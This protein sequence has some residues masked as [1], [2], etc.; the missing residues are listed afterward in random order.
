M[1]KELGIGLV[2]YKFMGKAHSNAWLNAPKFFDL[3]AQPVM[4]AVCGRTAAAVKPFADNW[5]WQSVET[6]YRK[7]I[8]RDDIHLIDVATPNHTHYAIAM[9]AIKARKHVACEKPLAM[10]TPQ[11][12]EMACAAKEAKLVHT[13]WFNYRRCPAAGLARQIIREGRLGVIR[14]VRAVYL[15]DWIVNPEFPLVWRLDKK[16][17]GSGAHGDLNAHLIDLTRF[18]TGLEF[19][20]VTGLA[21]TFIKQR[22]RVASDKGDLRAKSGKGT[23]KVTVDDTVLF[24]ARLQ[25]NVVA[26][27]EAT[28]FALGRRNHNRIEINGSKGS[29]AWCFERMNELEFFS[30]A[31]P[32][33]LQGFRTIQATEACH[34]YVGAYWPAGHG[35]GYEHAFVNQAADIVQ[36]T[37]ARRKIRPDFPDGLRCQEVMDAVLRSCKTKRWVAVKRHQ[38]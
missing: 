32:Q 7:L 2:G 20:E 16:I 1:Q 14:H 19:E 17:A 15:Q 25:K 6:D 13:V 26:T 34:P 8:R 22:P 37:H 11:A 24:L 12:H 10:T 28:R 35:L 38:V 3:P 23:G 5:G 18:I 30:G 4:K 21:E 9:A 27:F 31:D 33:H 29:L 36:A